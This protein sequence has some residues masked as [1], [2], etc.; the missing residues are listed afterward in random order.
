M[1]STSTPLDERSVALVE[2]HDANCCLGPRLVDRIPPAIVGGL[3]LVAMFGVACFALAAPLLS[4]WSLG[5]VIAGLV[6]VGSIRSRWRGSHAIDPN[7]VEDRALESA[8][9]RLLASHAE[10]ATVLAARRDSSGLGARLLDR[11]RDNVVDCGR[12]ARIANPATRYL[13]NHDRA[14]LVADANRLRD[15]AASSTDLVAAQTL[16]TAAEECERHVAMLDD[17]AVFRDR[18]RA[19][20]ELAISSL[21]AVTA[22]IVKL[23][24]LDDEELAGVA[25]TDTT[26]AMAD[27]LDALASARAACS[28]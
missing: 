12:I 2:V 22:G 17:L 14:A 4:Y 24:A 8:Y 11:S 9:R 5:A 18:V 1:T 13:A 25:N 15:S 7:E 28:T 26:V 16:R 20:L 6:G 10:L 19:R 3:G 23:Q 27:Q 21:Q